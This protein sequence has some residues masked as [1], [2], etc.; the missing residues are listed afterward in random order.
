MN[1]GL[2]GEK[3]KRYL[4]AMPP[5]YNVNII[6]IQDSRIGQWP[7]FQLSEKVFEHLQRVARQNSWEMNWLRNFGWSMLIL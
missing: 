5:A 1:P 4:C 2:L 7:S 6:L 3:R